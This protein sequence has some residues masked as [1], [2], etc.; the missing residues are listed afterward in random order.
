MQPLVALRKMCSTRRFHIFLCHGGWRPG[1]Q[2]ST[3][4][5]TQVVIGHAG[6]YYPPGKI[7]RVTAVSRISEPS[8]RGFCFQQL[9]IRRSFFFLFLGGG[10]RKE[11]D[12]QTRLHTHLTDISYSQSF[13]Q[14]LHQQT[15]KKKKKLEN[16]AHWCRT[17]QAKH[18]EKNH[19]AAPNC[20]R[21]QN[22]NCYSS[23]AFRRTMLLLLLERRRLHLLF[24]IK[25]SFKGQPQQPL[26]VAHRGFQRASPVL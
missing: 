12:R 16:N 13:L 9:H 14:S 15:Y 23:P 3:H 19:C 24:V 10:K 22:K 8:S 11:P 2:N 5:R 1:G 7:K 21:Q 4:R 6:D 25:G 17:R 26:V 20:P 18:K